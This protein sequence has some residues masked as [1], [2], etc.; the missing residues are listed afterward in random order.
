MSQISITD[1]TH[2]RTGP[3]KQR[4]QA[5][6]SN[7]NV[8][9][10]GRHVHVHVNLP[11][12]QDTLLRSF[13]RFRALSARHTPTSPEKA[14]VGGAHTDTEAA[15]TRGAGVL[16][17]AGSLSLPAQM[18]R[19]WPAAA[20]ARPFP[21]RSPASPY[22]SVAP[23]TWCPSCP[24]SYHALMHPAP[25]EPPSLPPLTTPAMVPGATRKV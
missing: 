7:A 14:C 2:A 21:L 23:T 4:A 5:P 9:L 20:V 8:T 10:Q 3:D 13:V 18:Y 11:S 12:R 25:V 6:L 15:Y 17:L 19:G 16:R 22:A 24:L 1:R